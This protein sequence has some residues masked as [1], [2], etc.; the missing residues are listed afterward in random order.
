MSESNER[1]RRANE[2][3]RD[4]TR[5]ANNEMNGYSSPLH[6]ITFSNFYIFAWRSGKFMDEM[7]SW[8][9]EQLSEFLE[10]MG[11]YVGEEKV[12]EWK[13]SPQKMRRDMEESMNQMNQMMDDEETLE[14]IKTATDEIVSLFTNPEKMEAALADIVKEIEDWDSGDL[15]DNSKIESARQKLLTG[16][17]RGVENIP[18]L[19]SVFDDSDMQEMLND[20]KKFRDNIKKRQIGRRGGVADSL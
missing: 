15:S 2:T 13:K 17:A 1:T 5:R 3:R 12:A 4:E 6:H 7:D 16:G 10:T 11:P 19:R 20:K 14:A 18:S 9:K 8:T